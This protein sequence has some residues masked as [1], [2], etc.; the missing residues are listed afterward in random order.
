MR[1][2]IAGCWLLACQVAPPIADTRSIAKPVVAADLERG[3]TEKRLT[4]LAEIIAIDPQART[5]SL[6]AGV[7][8]EAIRVL[9]EYKKSH[10]PGDDQGD[11]LGAYSAGLVRALAESNNP[12]FIPTLIQYNGMVS[13]ATSALARFGE[14]AVSPLLRVA[15]GPRGDLSQR[16]GAASALVQ[17]LRDHDLAP[18]AALSDRSRRQI[19]TFAEGLLTHN[20]RLES[21]QIGNLSDV[22]LA[23]GRQDLRAEVERLATNRDAWIM[24]GV[25]ESF[26]IDFGQRILRSRLKNE[27]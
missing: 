4:V 20:A 14:A 13:Y 24:H 1:W 23:T 15:S 21:D 25:T 16:G 2:L 22:A 26:S 5:P 27:P 3:S 10:V 6:L 18:T 17:M 11:I 7:H 9:G 12:A 19:E 8:R